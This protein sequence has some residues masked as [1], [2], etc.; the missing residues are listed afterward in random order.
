LVEAA[1]TTRSKTKDRMLAGEARGVRG[2]VGAR[3]G[4]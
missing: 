2:E 3:M 4:G 1:A